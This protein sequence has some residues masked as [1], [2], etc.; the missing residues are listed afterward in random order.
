MEEEKDKKRQWNEWN[1]KAQGED[2]VRGR[3]QQR[4]RQV[5]RAKGASKKK[6]NNIYQ[7]DVTMNL[8]LYDNQ[9]NRKVACVYTYMH[10]CVYIYAFMLCVLWFV[11]HTDVLPDFFGNFI[12]VTELL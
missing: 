11:I 10:V 4:G 2:L 7:E 8:V 12:W 3:D 6:H 5:E 9:K 1:I